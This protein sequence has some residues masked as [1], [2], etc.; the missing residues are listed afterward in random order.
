MINAKKIFVEGIEQTRTMSV[1]YDHFVNDLH[2]QHDQ[3]D[4]L[5]RFQIVYAVSGFDRLLHELIRLGVI[6]EFNG[7]RI[8]TNKFLNQSFKTETLLK[9]VEYSLSSYLPQS[10]IETT[11]FII[12]KEM[13]DKLS[14]LSF[15]APDKVK[16]GLSL[17][18]SESN[19]M[20]ALA[21]DMGINGISASIKQKALE[22]Q[23]TLI[24]ERRNQIA[25]EGDIDPC[26]NTKRSITKQDSEEALNFILNLGISIHKLVTDSCCYVTK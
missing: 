21:E 20:L 11:E 3:V 10:P 7:Q 14:Y 25:H 1:L 13:T 19:K 2:L 23:L 24:V 12:N 18:W 9:A 8:K 5:L 16:D 22:Q 6:E 15:Q 26:S 4:D 17:I